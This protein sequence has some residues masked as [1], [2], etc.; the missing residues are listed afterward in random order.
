MI[1]WGAL[2]GDDQ[3]AHD[4]DDVALRDSSAGG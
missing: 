4:G 1:F 2:G 3:E